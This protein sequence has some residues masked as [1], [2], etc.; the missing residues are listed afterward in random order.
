MAARQ[1]ARRRNLQAV[2]NVY[3]YVRCH[4]LRHT[5]EAV[6]AVPGIRLRPRYGTLVTFRCVHCGTLR[7][8][9]I[10]RLTGELHYRQYLRPDDYGH[11]H[12]TMAQW[13]VILLDELPADLLTDMDEAQ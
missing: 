8:D 6:G 13:R 1:P 10:G 11:E 3:P 5:F 12:L 7:L 2:T 9:V 4:V